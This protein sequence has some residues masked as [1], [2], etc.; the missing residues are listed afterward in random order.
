MQVHDEILI[1]VPAAAAYPGMRMLEA[2]MRAGLLAVF[3]EADELGLAGKA[4]VQAS[5]GW[6]WAQVH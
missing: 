2:A 4:L 5:A 1:Q 3:P 6:N